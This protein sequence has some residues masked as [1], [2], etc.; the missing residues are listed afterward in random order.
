MPEATPSEPSYAERQIAIKRQDTERP[1]VV[2]L[3]VA[4]ELDLLTANVLDE[5]LKA[6]LVPPNEIVV[7]DMSE[8]HFLASAGL[9]TLL[10]G[11]ESAKS[12]GIDLRLVANARV[13]LRPLEITG[14][15]STFTVF[16]SVEAALA[17][18]GA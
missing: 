7:L 9:S 17:T 18:N 5:E 3:S 2:V 8:V 4:G 12:G 10:A 11:A 13:I 15:R 16:D 1:G 6:T 14:I